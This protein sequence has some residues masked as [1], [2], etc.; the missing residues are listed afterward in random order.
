MLEAFA[1]VILGAVLIPI[2]SL[3]YGFAVEL[4]YPMPEVLINGLMIT[5]SYIWGTIQVRS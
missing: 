3:S 5:I 1:M 4:A 2:L